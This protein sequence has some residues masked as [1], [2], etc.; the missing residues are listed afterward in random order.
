MNIHATDDVQRYHCYCCD[1]TFKEPFPDHYDVTPCL[2]CDCDA[3]N[4][5]FALPEDLDE[6]H[7]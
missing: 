7:R 3:L 2:A 1:V 6:Q 4:I 5:L